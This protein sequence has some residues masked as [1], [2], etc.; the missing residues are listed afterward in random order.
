M[1]VVLLGRRPLEVMVGISTLATVFQRT[2]AD[3]FVKKSPLSLG[4]QIP[5][6]QSDKNTNT[7]GTGCVSGLGTLAICL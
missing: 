7:Y 5:P 4:T 3:Y 2:R 1:E 6:S